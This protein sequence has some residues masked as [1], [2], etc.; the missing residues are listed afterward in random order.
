AAVKRGIL[1]SGKVFYDLAEARKKSG[2]ERIAIV[3]FEQFYPFPFTG[4]REILNRYPNTEQLAWVQEEPKNMGGWGFMEERLENLLPR[5]DR[6]IY[7]G[8][9][10][11]ASPA[12]GSY[13]IHQQEQAKFIEEALTI[14]WRGFYSLLG[15]PSGRSET[16]TFDNCRWRY[17]ATFFVPQ[18]T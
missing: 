11:S 12:T 10:P 9:S 15:F 17:L 1:C 13:A 14:D 3:R 7:I 18:S 4:L 16:T 5:C 2:E 6:P 8:R